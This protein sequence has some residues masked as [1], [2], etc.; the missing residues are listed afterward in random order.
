MIRL[1]KN[2][3]FRKIN[4]ARE[5]FEITIEGNPNYL[6]ICVEA[7]DTGIMTLGLATMVAMG[8][9]IYSQKRRKN[10]IW[11]LDK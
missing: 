2:I 3:K 1:E 9:N 4:G 5:K 7:G 8:A 6:Y 11:E 10:S